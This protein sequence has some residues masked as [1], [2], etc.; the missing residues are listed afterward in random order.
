MSFY[1]PFK[2]TSF[3]KLSRKE[4]ESWGVHG[5]Y[6]RREV[7]VAFMRELRMGSALFTWMSHLNFHAKHLI[8]I[9]R[10]IGCYCMC[11][12]AV[13]LISVFTSIACCRL[14]FPAI[15]STWMFGL[16]GCCR[17]WFLALFNLKVRLVGCHRLWFLAIDSIWKFR[18]IGCHR[19]CRRRNFQ[20]QACTKLQLQQ[21]WIVN[22]RATCCSR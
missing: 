14:C 1:C 8:W 7:K 19:L 22:R 10:L 18:L 4:L 15:H 5:F 6:G 2:S 3:I 16:I 9:F 11:F 12:R 13:H 17:L 21:C 20:V